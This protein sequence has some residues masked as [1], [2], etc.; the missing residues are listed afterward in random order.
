LT[1]ELTSGFACSRRT[2]SSI[3]LLGPG[4]VSLAPV[5]LITSGLLPYA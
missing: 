2:V 5:D 4:S 3:A 1:A